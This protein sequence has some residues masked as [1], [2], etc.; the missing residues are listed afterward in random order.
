MLNVSR[1]LGDIQQ[2]PANAL[3]LSCGQSE[4]GTLKV[5]H[6]VPTNKLMNTPKT[7]DGTLLKS[8]D[9]FAGFDPDEHEMLTM[10]GYDDCIVGVVERY[11][12]KPIV[13]YDKEK[14]LQR[15]ESEGCDRD[16]AEEFFYFNQIGAWVGDS[17]PCFLSANTSTMASEAKEGQP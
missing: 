1:G 6:R 11:G 14:V 16:E 8:T 2:P 7:D 3:R 17:T 5:T 12:Q 10:D 15:L 9:L 4:N 13:C